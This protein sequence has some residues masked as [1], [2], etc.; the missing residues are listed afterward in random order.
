MAQTRQSVVASL[1]RLGFYPSA[2]KGRKLPYLA[3]L[4][5]TQRQAVRF[6]PF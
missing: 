1:V 2:L 4:L 3:A 5:R 6:C